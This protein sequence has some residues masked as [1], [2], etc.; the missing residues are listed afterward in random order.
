M[1]AARHARRRNQ[2]GRKASGAR[3]GLLTQVTAGVALATA[4]TPLI[5]R[6]AGPVS[7]LSVAPRVVEDD[8]R[9]CR[10]GA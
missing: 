10:T 3:S 2:K 9:L 6:A 8:D 7:G 1:S 5:A 4:L